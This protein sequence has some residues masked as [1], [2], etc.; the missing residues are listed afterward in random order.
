[1]SSKTTGWTR[2]AALA[3]LAAGVVAAGAFA[4][5]ANAEGVTPTQLTNAGWT[6]IQPRVDP[7]ILL[8]APPGVGLPPLPGTL[9]FADRAPSYEFL[10]FEFATG[11]FIGTQHLLRPDIYEHGKPP[12]PQQPG[13]EYL[14]NPR[15]GLWFCLRV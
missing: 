15:N 8:C 3:A 2:R 4:T 9:G 11:A 13:G 6:C 14:Y 1:M 5:T 12:C 10:V 7:T